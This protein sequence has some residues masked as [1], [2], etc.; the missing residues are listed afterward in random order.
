M[1]SPHDAVS[2]VCRLQLRDYDQYHACTA[3]TEPANPEITPA[4]ADVAIN[5]DGTKTVAVKA[6]IESATVEKYSL[7]S[8]TIESPEAR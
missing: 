7:A 2:R 6:D 5:G 1:R 3:L 4:L 8:W